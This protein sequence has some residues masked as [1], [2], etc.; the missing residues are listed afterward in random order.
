M[1]GFLRQED[2]PDAERTA[3]ASG[4]WHSSGGRGK[5]CAQHSQALPLTDLENGVLA[6]HLPSFR[7]K[8]QI[9]CFLCLSVRSNTRSCLKFP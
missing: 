7:K 4:T 8:N 3:V 1:C 2:G 9:L 5:L 6:T